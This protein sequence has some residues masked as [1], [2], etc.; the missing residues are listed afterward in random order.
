V[1]EW[2]VAAGLGALAMFML[3]QGIAE[4][5]KK[6]QAKH[7]KPPLRVKQ[8]HGIKIEEF[9]NKFP[10]MKFNIT[11]VR[12]DGDELLGFV[13]SNE[14]DKEQCILYFGNDSNLEPYW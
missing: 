14:E 1:S 5:A 7:T 6:I 10:D 8:G 3:L 4:L 11:G 12:V 13:L 9:K 2:W